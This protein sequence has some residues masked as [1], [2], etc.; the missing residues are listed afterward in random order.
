MGPDGMHGV[1]LKKFWPFLKDDIMNLFEEFFRNNLDISH[2]NYTY[3]VL[4]LKLQEANRMVNFRPI[5]LCNIIYTLLSKVHNNQLP[6]ILSFLISPMQS[7]FVPDCLITIMIL[8]R[9]RV[10]I[11]YSQSSMIISILWN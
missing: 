3:L 10:F 6:S 5:S 7:A 1:F 11:T 8:L 9:L 2:L 4:I